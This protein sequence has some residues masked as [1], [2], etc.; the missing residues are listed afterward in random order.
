MAELWQHTATEIAGLIKAR[1][2]SATEVAK[3][4]LSRLEA[5][6]PAINAIVQRTDEEALAAA[7]A[8]DGAIARGDDPGPLGG[9]PITIKVNVDQ[10][11]LATTNGLRLQ[12]GLVA[13][14][15]NPLVAN[16]RRAGAVIV[17]RTN[18]PAFSLRWFTRNSL[19]GHTLNPVNRALT[20]GGSSGGAAA[21]TAAGIGAIGHGNDIGGSIRY[22][23]YACGIHGIRPTPGRVPTFNATGADRHIGA[24]LMAVNGPLARSIAD[25]KVGL[26]AMSAKDL[27]D[28]WWTP[29]PLDTGSF[30]R[31]AALTVAPEGLKV[32][33]AV[34]AALREA[35]ARLVDAGWEVHELVCPPFRQPAR[36]QAQLW[37]A[38]FRRTGAA[39]I[40]QE[41]DPDATFVYAQM[42][43]LCPAPDMNALMD[44]LQARLGFLRQWAL[45]LEQYPVL[46]CP[47]SAETPFPDLLDVASPDAFDRVMEA[48]LTQVGLPFMGLPG[49]TVTTSISNG[50]PCG[51]Q[52][53]AGR[54]R[55]DVLLA[56]GADIEARGPR[57]AIAEP[58]RGA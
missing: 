6:N 25:L 20:P 10:T 45:F 4:A 5:V 26:A 2:V 27:R 19:H 16:L 32:Q 52:L 42:A 1:K 57:I 11:G 31:R 21:A 8:I 24:Q 37:L 34:E 17:G 47:V 55:E 35:A 28:P 46:I 36:L 14:E 43:R 23:A 53:V 54:F 15:D 12:A 44:A 22:P 56:A 49:L 38:E 51:A 18:T 39:A 41:A 9:A 13:K 33:P 48:Q 50:V 58:A 7:R 30:V 3:A 29:A 40:E